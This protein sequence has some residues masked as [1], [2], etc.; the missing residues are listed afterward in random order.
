[1]FFFKSRYQ[2]NLERFKFYISEIINRANAKYHTPD[3]MPYI[4]Q[5]LE[6]TIKNSKSSFEKWDE[7]TN[8]ERYAYSALYN[9]CF[10]VLTSG[11]MHI[12]RGVLN[13]LL[14]CDK[15]L[16]IIDEALLY[17]VRIGEI[18]ESQMREQKA[19]L[20]EQISG[21]TDDIMTSFSKAK[22]VDPRLIK[23]LK[24]LQEYIEKV[25]DELERIEKIGYKAA[26]VR[27]EDCK[28]LREGQLERQRDYNELLDEHPE[29]SGFA[30]IH[31]D[32]YKD[33]W[34]RDDKEYE[35]LDVVE[36]DCEKRVKKSSKLFRNVRIGENE[37]Y[38]MYCISN[39]FIRKDKETGQTVFFGK[40]SVPTY[41][42][43]DKQTGEMVAITDEV[44]ASIY[45]GWFYWYD[46]GS[47]YSDK[48]LYRTSLD[49]KTIEKL[50]WLSNRKTT[51]A[52]HIVSEDVVRNM[53][54]SEDKLIIEVYRKSTGTRYNI[55]VC[56]IDNEL[57]IQN[58]GLEERKD[59]QS[60]AESE[61]EPLQCATTQQEVVTEQNPP[62]TNDNTGST[63]SDMSVSKEE[64]ATDYIYATAANGVAVRIPKDHYA[65]WAESQE[66]IKQGVQT[67]ADIQKEE[68]LKQG[69]KKLLQGRD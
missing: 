14:P 48:F 38:I 54:L 57:I 7:N 69:L 61:S 28:H 10:S 11:S 47:T 15:L 40:G 8:V 33:R 52:G 55:T 17:A 16:Y 64:R 68:E 59:R 20:N 60:C 44:S 22:Q 6:L 65:Q 13:S 32:T 63:T 66:R 25:D 18:S 5:G 43:R 37:R 27:F 4:K 62:N 39:S 49:G 45:N 26:G 12:Y 56:D 58:E 2:K 19:L 3:C 29:V 50:D 42:D 1:M 67:K 21:N 53:F 46:N 9:I 36:V 31:I 34:L 23:L 41:Y 24:D 35:F 51:H 30:R